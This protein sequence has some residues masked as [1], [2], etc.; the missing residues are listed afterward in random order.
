MRRWNAAALATAL[1]TCR[2]RGVRLTT[3]RRAAATILKALRMRELR[4]WT[5]AWA[6]HAQHAGE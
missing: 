5:N 4:G 6:E 3:Q 2:E 1:N